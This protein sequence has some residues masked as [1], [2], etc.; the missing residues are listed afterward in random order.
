[1]TLLVRAVW[2]LTPAAVQA[3]TSSD[4]TA[5]QWVVAAG[6]VLFIGF[7]EGY[8]GF[9]RA[10]APRVV[11][12]A[13]HLA[14]APRLLDAALA[15]AFCMGLLHASRRRLVTSWAVVAGIIG[16]VA[17]VRAVPQP[18]RGMIDAGVVVGLAW[19]VVAIVV[20]ATRALAGHTPRVSLDLPVDAA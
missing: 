7:L 10:F 11:A 13:H 17:A 5:W 4:L 15:P 9:Q 12:R 19:G 8:R 16:L 6:G 2:R 18:Y 14:R 20:F 3:F 1:M